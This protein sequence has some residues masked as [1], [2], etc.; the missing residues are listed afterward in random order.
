M[1]HGI[2]PFA[3]VFRHG[4]RPDPFFRAVHDR[5]RPKHAFSSKIVLPNGEVMTSH[6]QYCAWVA[7]HIP[8]FQDRTY[9]VL[10]WHRFQREVV[11]Y[12]GK[13]ARWKDGSPVSHQ[14]PIVKK[15]HLLLEECVMG[16]P[17]PLVQRFVFAKPYA[18]RG[19]GL[20]FKDGTLHLEYFSN[21]LNERW[22][23]VMG[24]HVED[25]YRSQLKRD[26]ER[27]TGLPVISTPDASTQTPVI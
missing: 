6:L 22:H 5:L 1:F 17:V 19:G 23:P 27:L 14:T 15:S 3:T 12:P 13:G 26:V 2:V 11:L 16:N 10:S 18:L 9:F 24:G 25:A 4:V 8:S 21:V 20:L 7:R